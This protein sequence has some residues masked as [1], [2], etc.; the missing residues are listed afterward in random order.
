MSLVALSITFWALWWG[1]VQR[2]HREHCAFTRCSKVSV[3]RTTRN[4]VEDWDFRITTGPKRPLPDVRLALERVSLENVFATCVELG[5]IAPCLSAAVAA[6]LQST[7]SIVII[8]D[9]LNR[10]AHTKSV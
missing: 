1:N 10:E 4:G 5:F 3:D 2:K 6:R 9:W 8:N 7:G